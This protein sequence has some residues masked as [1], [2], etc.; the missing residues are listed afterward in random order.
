MTLVQT[1]N[2]VIDSVGPLPSSINVSVSYQLKR[3]GSYQYADPTPGSTNTFLSSFVGSLVI[4]E[5]SHTGTFNVCGGTDLTAGAGTN[6]RVIQLFAMNIL[7]AV[8]T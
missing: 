4:S 3:D 7:Y 2:S 5:V 6:L 8:I 1:D